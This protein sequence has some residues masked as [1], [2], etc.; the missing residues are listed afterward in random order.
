MNTPTLFYRALQQYLKHWGFGH[1]VFYSP[2]VA[3]E[4]KKLSRMNHAIDPCKEKLAVLLCVCRCD[5]SL[6]ELLELSSHESM[7]DYFNQAL[8]RQIAEHEEQIRILRAKL[9]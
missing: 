9:K 3:H 4:L 6:M 2:T 8:L 5:K 7:R 1:R